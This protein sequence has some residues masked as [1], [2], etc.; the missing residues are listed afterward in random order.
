M[1]VSRTI[2]GVT[3]LNPDSKKEILALRHINTTSSV[4]SPS[5]HSLDIL[6]ASSFPDTLP[7]GNLPASGQG[8]P[9]AL[10]G[11]I[12][13]SDGLCTPSSNLQPSNE[14]RGTQKTWKKAQPKRK[15]TQN[16]PPENHGTAVGGSKKRGRPR[17]DTA[18]ET[19]SEV[20]GL[21]PI[22]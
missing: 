3:A 9:S 15:S 17:V 6:S 21:L 1:V 2:P 12:L 8:A 16:G 18:A 22:L 4:M 11:G 13:I 19:A 10:Y 20:S 5:D 14:V 7:Q